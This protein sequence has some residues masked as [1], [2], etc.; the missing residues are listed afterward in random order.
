MLR[1]KAYTPNYMYLIMYM[2]CYYKPSLELKHDRPESI[3]VRGGSFVLL[4]AGGGKGEF[5]YHSR[6]G[7][8]RVERALACRSADSGGFSGRASGV[9][10]KPFV[11]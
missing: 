9:G 7:S 4:E 5:S 11:A 6:S 2:C 1:G 8:G 10:G 3:R